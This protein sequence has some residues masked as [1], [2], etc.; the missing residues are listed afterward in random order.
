MAKKRP[1]GVTF[2]GVL[3]WIEAALYIVGGI[4]ALL[5]IGTTAPAGSGY[6]LTVFIFSLIL[7]VLLLAVSAALMRGSNGARILVSIV[8]V[9]AVIGGVGAAFSGQLVGGIVNA[10]VA[11]VGLVMLYSQRA[12]A[13]FRV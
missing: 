11:V 6:R 13:F 1:A 4:L 5:G 3:I 7:G 9:L 10:V 8:L 2:I 12:D